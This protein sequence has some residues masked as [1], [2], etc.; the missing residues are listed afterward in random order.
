MYGKN[1]SDETRIKISETK[2]AYPVWKKE[3]IKKKMA[4][5]I[6]AYPDWKKEEIHVRKSEAQ[7]GHVMSEENKK[8]LSEV[9][10]GRIPWNKGK[11]LTEEHRKHIEEGHIRK[12]VIRND[13]VV[14]LSVT[15]AANALGVRP[16]AI[17]SVLHGRSKKTCGYTFTLG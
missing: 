13:G 8:R 4:E 12:K 6:S 11:L 1:H 7:K 2:K 9:N 15:E 14:F 16:S 17:S 5:T 3:E 10:T